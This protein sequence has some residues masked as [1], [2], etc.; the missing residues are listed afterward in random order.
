MS[1]PKK[2]CP[3]CVAV[4]PA[5]SDYFYR[6]ASRPS[7]LGDY[8]KPCARQHVSAC[9]K[10]EPGR[11]KRYSEKWRRANPSAQLQATL[12]WRAKN[13]ERVREHRRRNEAK[14]RRQPGVRLTAG[15]SR[16]IRKHIKSGSKA[17]RRWESLVGYSLAEL[18]QHIERQ[19]E[20]G[21]DWQNM[22]Q[23]HIDHRIPICNFNFTTPDDP[24]FKRCWA[25]SNLQPLWAP[26]NCSKS[27]RRTVLI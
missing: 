9:L 17:G 22:G 13:I 24:D 11:R 15:I 3:K 5:T 25:L 26:E 18:M 16:S 23:W 8:C 12:A 10:K 4:L 20:K 6:N 27:G 19:F 7:G 2:V 1:T 21:M 14:R